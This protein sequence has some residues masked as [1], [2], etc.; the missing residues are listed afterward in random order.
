[1]D[2]FVKN[3]NGLIG[4]YGL[5]LKENQLTTVTK[6]MTAQLNKIINLY[7][8]L[9]DDLLTVDFFSEE[10]QKKLLFKVEQAADFIWNHWWKTDEQCDQYELDYLKNVRQLNS[11]IFRLYE[12]TKE[13]EK[14]RLPKDQGIEELCLNFKFQPTWIDIIKYIN[15]NNICSSKLQ[16][17]SYLTELTLWFD[18]LIHITKYYIKDLGTENLLIWPVVDCLFNPFHK[19]CI[20]SI[21]I[22]FRPIDTFYIGTCAYFYTQLYLYGGCPFQ[23]KVLIMHSYRLFVI[24]RSQRIDQWSDNMLYCMRKVL[25][26]LI[27]DYKT[28]FPP[29]SRFDSGSNEKESFLPNHEEYMEA[30]LKILTHQKFNQKDTASLSPDEE[31]LIKL[32]I[33][34]LILTSTCPVDNNMKEWLRSK[35][36]IEICSTYIHPSYGSVQLY[37]LSLVVILADETFLE[38]RK[39][40]N[41]IVRISFDILNN[42][43]QLRELSYD[44]INYFKVFLTILHHKSIQEAIG[45]LNKVYYFLL[46]FDRDTYPLGDILWTLSFSSIVKKQLNEQIQM[47]QASRTDCLGLLW[48]LGDCSGVRALRSIKCT[49]YPDPK[50]KAFEIQQDIILDCSLNDEK[51]CEQIYFALIATGFRVWFLRE[52]ES[53]TETF[54]LQWKIEAC[55]SIKTMVICLSENYEKSNVCR[56]VLQYAL[57]KQL[58]IVPI[59][60]GKQY[61]MQSYLEDNFNQIE[62]INFTQLIFDDAIHLL[63]NSLR[64]LN[65]ERSQLTESSLSAVTYLDFYEACKNNDFQQ[66]KEYLPQMSL[67]QVNEIHPDGDTALH[68]AVCN[69]NKDIIRLL[70]HKGASRSIRDAVHKMTAY[71]GAHDSILKDLFKRLTIFPRFLTDLSYQLLEWTN[72][73]LSSADQSL[74]STNYDEILMTTR[75]ICFLLNE[76]SLKDKMIINWFLNKATNDATYI[77]RAF[78]S[79]THFSIAF[80][81]YLLENTVKETQTY[82]LI[83]ILKTCHTLEA[84]AF[85]GETYRGMLVSKEDVTKYGVG[86]KVTIATFLSTTKDLLQAEVAALDGHGDYVRGTCDL[87]FCYVPAICIY[88]I[89]RHH[90]AYNIENISEIPDEKEVLILPHSIFIVKIISEYDEI[91]RNGIIYQLEL[92]ECD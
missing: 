85:L 52:I 64:N 60:I 41:R 65:E 34:Y 13:K 21:D 87:N 78:T 30:L 29:P 26:L 61:K 62:I 48:T 6:R 47:L 83:H 71:E 31:K 57:R 16:N 88:R 12:P 9:A 89:R 42:E 72:D 75:N 76:I 1:M 63:S 20:L 33:R 11:K 53:G 86:S 19:Q 43:C 45:R 70:L 40:A 4:K 35:R 77:L 37:V 91:A 14:K 24:H 15:S 56:A 49:G 5:D 79:A 46:H 92:E 82:G 32:V 54:V 44:K 39:M 81:K 18:L 59:I 23:I 50:P 67:D 2:D 28:T 3:L 55:D 7:L 68:T 36:A 74:I 51:T 58:R 73:I 69:N 90:T 8:N 66:V 17:S 22:N 38:C 80:N 27:E 10:Q 84:C 25:A